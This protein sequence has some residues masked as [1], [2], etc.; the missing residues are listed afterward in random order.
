M[1][2]RFLANWTVIGCVA[3]ILLAAHFSTAQTRD[4]AEAALKAADDK[5]TIEGNLR[6]AIEM[7]KKIADGKDRAQAAKALIRIA[8]CYLKLGDSESRKIYERVVRDFGDQVDAVK[9]ARARLGTNA[10]LEATGLTRQVWTGPSVD[11]YGSVSPDGR[12]ISFTDWNTGDLAL[13]DL[14]SS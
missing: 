5:A 2:N 6:G 11:V 13:H 4:K 3:T 10:A 7:Y 9:I 12:F 1:R 14:G 8:E